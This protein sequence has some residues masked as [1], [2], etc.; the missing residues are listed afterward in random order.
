MA[1]AVFPALTRSTI[2]WVTMFAGSS[3]GVD[4][5][6]ARAA[7]ELAGHLA[8]AGIGV[9]YGGGGAGLM[10]AAADGALAKGGAVVG[11]IPQALMDRELGHQG[12]TRLEVVADMHERKRRMA[13]LGDAF[14]ALP[15]GIGQGA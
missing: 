15:G 6:Y 2:A 10:G 14:V 12:V 4:P 11:V 8:S 3:A 9:V 7:S 5:A 13:A 1:D